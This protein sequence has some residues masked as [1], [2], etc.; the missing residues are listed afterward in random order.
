VD[1]YLTKPVQAEALAACLAHWL[2]PEAGG[3]S[4]PA[5]GRADGPTAIGR[6]V[7]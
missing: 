3:R 2:E 1:D 4:G 6:K 7:L 5:A